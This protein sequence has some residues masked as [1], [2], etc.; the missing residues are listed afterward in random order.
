FWGGFI[1]RSA[2]VL[3]A[4]LGIDAIANGEPT[5]PPFY[6]DKSNLLVYLDADGKPVPAKSPADWAK[7]REHILANMQQV[8]GPL[9]AESNKVPLDLKVEGEETL[10]KVVRKKISF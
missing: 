5:K 3:F 7:R 1:M 2:I 9:P 6:S 4:L 8:M 10:A